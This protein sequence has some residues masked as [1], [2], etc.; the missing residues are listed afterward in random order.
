MAKSLEKTEKGW[1][2]YR[3][4]GE[5]FSVAAG[6]FELIAAPCCCLFAHFSQFPKFGAGPF[7]SADGGQLGHLGK[8]PLRGTGFNCGSSKFRDRPFPMPWAICAL[9][10]IQLERNCEGMSFEFAY[11]FKQDAPRSRFQDLDDVVLTAAV[12]GDHGVAIPAGTLGTILSVHGDGKSYVVEFDEPDGVLATVLPNQI[13]T[14][15]PSRQ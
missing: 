13:E 3:C 9:A 6:I 7:G 5:I 1:H 4:H 12:V 8:S 2:P 11:R 14:A 10:G 15:G